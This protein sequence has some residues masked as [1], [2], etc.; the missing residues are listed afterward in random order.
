MRQRH[1]TSRGCSL[2]D[3][4]FHAVGSGQRESPGRPHPAVAGPPVPRGPL[5]DPDVTGE[6]LDKPVRRELSTLRA[7]AAE[8][9]AK[10]LVM[11]ARLLDDEPELA[12]AHAEAARKHGP[13]IAV[14]RSA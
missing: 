2:D 5:V 4:W 11:V 1:L 3:Q 10:H 9:A 8:S 14:I 7:E 12:Y 6:E 13:R